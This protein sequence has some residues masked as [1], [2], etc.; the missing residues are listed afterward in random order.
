MLYRMGSSS[1]RK[2]CHVRQMIPP[3][4]FIPLL[5]GVGSHRRRAEKM[6]YT[7][8]LFPHRRGKGHL[9]GSGFMDIH[10][11]CIFFVG[12]GWEDYC[13]T[14]VIKLKRTNSPTAF[15]L[16]ALFYARFHLLAILLHAARDIKWVSSSSSSGSVVPRIRPLQPTNPI[17][18]RDGIWDGAHG[19]SRDR[20]S[21]AL[22][23]MCWRRSRWEAL[24]ASR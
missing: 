19:I 16:G 9:F 21:D 23:G 18:T 17:F 4:L 12:R 13:D 10:I 15:D 1:R 2:S 8:L 22:S 3:L 7:T 20:E 11:Y 14:R 5:S 6:D 24:V